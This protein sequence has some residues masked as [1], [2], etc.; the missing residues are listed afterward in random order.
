MDKTTFSEFNFI[1]QHRKK[2]QE[3]MCAE[4]NEDTI[5]LSVMQLLVQEKTGYE[6]VKFLRGRG[7]RKIEENEWIVYTFL[8][9]MEQDGYIHSCWNDSNI[10]HYQLNNKGTKLYENGK[11]SIQLNHLHSK[12]Y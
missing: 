6:L 8:H 11:N 5:F 1:E 12:H 3:K 4:E 9:Q 7:I 10:K 2:I